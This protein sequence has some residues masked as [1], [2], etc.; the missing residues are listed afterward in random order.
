MK[1]YHFQDPTVK[2]FI[3]SFAFENVIPPYTSNF[4]LGVGLF[5]FWHISLWWRGHMSILKNK[6]KYFN[7]PHRVNNTPLKNTR[8]WS[9]LLYNSPKNNIILIVLHYM[10]Y[11]NTVHHHKVLFTLQIAQVSVSSHHF[12]ATNICS[13]QQNDGHWIDKLIWN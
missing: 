11:C 12:S 6:S 1:S 9:L 4:P 8:T 2:Y 5:K 13:G 10:H 7:P 3:A